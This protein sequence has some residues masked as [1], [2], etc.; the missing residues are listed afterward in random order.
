MFSQNK[1]R[2]L[3]QKG[4]KEG[5]A[6]FAP[7]GAPTKDISQVVSREDMAEI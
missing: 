3:K 4:D 7:V 2:I 5:E 6:F 1:N